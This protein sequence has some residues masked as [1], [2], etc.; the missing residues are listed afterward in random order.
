MRTVRDGRKRESGRYE[1]GERIE[2]GKEGN[3]PLLGPSKSYIRSATGQ[4]HLNVLK[5]VCELEAIIAD[6]ADRM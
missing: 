4:L 1:K 2:E 5:C 6:I 3:S